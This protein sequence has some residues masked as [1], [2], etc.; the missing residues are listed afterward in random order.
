MEALSSSIFTN[1]IL[2]IASLCKLSYQKTKKQNDGH[3]DDEKYSMCI[4]KFE[5]STKWYDENGQIE[6]GRNAVEKHRW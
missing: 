2:L 1:I 5:L 6:S 4:D 3:D